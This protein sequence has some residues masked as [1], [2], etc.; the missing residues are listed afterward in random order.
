MQTNRDKQASE[1]RGSAHTEN[2]MD[3]EDPTQ[4][5]LDLVTALHSWSRGSGEACARTFLWK[6]DLRFGRCCLK[7]G[8]TKTVA[9]YLYSLPSRPKL[10]HLLKNQNYEGYVQ[11]TQ[12]GIFSTS[13]K[14]WWLDNSRSQSPQWR[15]WIPEQSPARCRGTRSRHSVDTILSV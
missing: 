9:Q 4:G 8:D 7:S 14:V 10:R 13:R 12:W 6:R 3:E 2:E 15:K 1:S 11:K 5:I